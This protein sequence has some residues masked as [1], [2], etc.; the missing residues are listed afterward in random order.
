M[1]LEGEKSEPAPV[2]YMMYEMKK[3][4]DSYILTA[5]KDLSDE[6]KDVP[7]PT[8]SSMPEA[9]SSSQS[10]SSS[11]SSSSSQDTTS[12]EQSSSSQTEQISSAVQS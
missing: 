8:S 6:L 11:S 4:G 7:Y 2:K 1:N 3:S 5:I 12:S 10:S 9:P